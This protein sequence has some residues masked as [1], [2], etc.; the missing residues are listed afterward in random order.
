[1][2]TF[3][4]MAAVAVIAIAV[5]LIAVLSRGDAPQSASR[6]TTSAVAGSARDCGNMTGVDKERCLQQK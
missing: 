4:I 1:M 2:R 5:A 3:Y 6:D